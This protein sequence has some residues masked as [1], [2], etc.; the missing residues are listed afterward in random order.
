MSDIKYLSDSSSLVSA[1]QMQVILENLCD[2]ADETLSSE[3]VEKITCRV[4][5]CSR[6]YQMVLKEALTEMNLHRLANF[7]FIPKK[8]R[9]RSLQVS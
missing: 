9:N 5:D 4:N 6:P 7:V 2:F 1:F 3:Q 8:L